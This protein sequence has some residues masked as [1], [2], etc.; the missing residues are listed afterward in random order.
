MTFSL[1]AGES[2]EEAGEGCDGC[3]G[4]AGGGGGHAERKRELER[5]RRNLIN[6][7]FAELGCE[8]QRSEKDDSHD[9]STDRARVKR[10]RMD[11]EAL[12]KEAT[13][14]LLVQHNELTAANARLKDLLAQIDAMRVEMRDLRKDKSL[15]RIELE[16]L[17]TSNTNL[18]KVIQQC[19][20]SKLS[21][22]LDPTKLATDV[23][24]PATSETEVQEAFCMP[25][26]SARALDDAF[27]T[28]ASP[29][30]GRVQDAGISSKELQNGL[31]GGRKVGVVAATAVAA[32]AAAG[33]A[34]ASASASASP[35]AAVTA[36]AASSV[37]GDKQNEGMYGGINIGLSSQMEYDG[38]NTRLFLSSF[39]FN[40]NNV[41]NSIPTLAGGHGDAV[42]VE[43]EQSD[44]IDKGQTGVSL[45]LSSQTFTQASSFDNDNS[46][47]TG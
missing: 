15:L 29:D 3:E 40:G 36:V 30:G 37:T 4:G 13:M 42:N 47:F 20:Y 27:G 23:F 39:E 1:N 35:S 17:R 22:L 18:W 28:I 32:T 16:R 24:A 34:K 7:R 6:M 46:E 14:R 38:Y 31:A 41:F 45:P 33:I 12:L 2:S 25:S 19:Q 26:V 10:P 11:K 21:A 44:G 9:A 43:R 5:N 8:L